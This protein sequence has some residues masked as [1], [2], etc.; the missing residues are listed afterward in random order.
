[1][2]FEKLSPATAMN[3]ETRSASSRISTEA[4]E[5]AAEAVE[6]L[7]SYFHPIETGDPRIFLSGAIEL[8]ARYPQAVIEQALDVSVGLPSKHKWWPRISEMKE[9]LDDLHWPIKFQNQWDA[10]AREQI[11]LR[12]TAI[13]DQS[14]QTSL[15]APTPQIAWN[16]RFGISKADWDAIPDQP[17]TFRKLPDPVASTDP[18]KESST[19]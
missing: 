19:A 17:E 7:S 2:S 6:R 18:P 3:F 5:R 15:P 9:T 4:R 1:M 10:R 11:A 13:T 8:F 14:A 12:R 16:E